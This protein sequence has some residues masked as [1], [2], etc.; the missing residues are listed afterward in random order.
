MVNAV[1]INIIIELFI[2]SSVSPK[3][4]GWKTLE[5]LDS[6]QMGQGGL[7]DCGLCTLLVFLALSSR[8]EETLLLWDLCNSCLAGAQTFESRLVSVVGQRR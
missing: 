6:V 4:P 8:Y 1:Y 2:V 7:R 5:H 3:C